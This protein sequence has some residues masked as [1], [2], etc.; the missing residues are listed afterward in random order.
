[1]SPP[2]TH[3]NQIQGKKSEAEACRYLKKSGYKILFRR[4]RSYW[5]EIDIIAQRKMEICFIEVKFRSTP[6]F[7]DPLEA[8]TLEKINRM[9]RTAEHFLKTH[10][11]YQTL[12]CKYLAIAHR[13][14]D[15]KNPMELIEIYPY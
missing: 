14:F 2:S 3:W 4:F 13:P 6:H 9:Q 5:G 1:M 11:K 15:P 7:G 8:I 10:Q 12:S